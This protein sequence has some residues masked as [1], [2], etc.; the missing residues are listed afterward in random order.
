MAGTRLSKYG[1]AIAE[2]TGMGRIWIG[3]VLLATVT[4][5]PELFTGISS[6]AIIGNPDLTL[7]DL[8]GSNLINLFIIAI[9]DV[10]YTRGPILHYLGTGLVLAAIAS[11]FLIGIAAASI[12]VAQ[13]V[14]SMGLFNYIGI[15]SPVIF[16]LYLAI[17]YMLIR[18][19]RSQQSQTVTESPH[20]SNHEDISLKRVITFFVIISLAL[21]IYSPSFLFR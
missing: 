14:S 4:S 13:N 6:V 8:F 16:C 5:L 17:Q 15:Y 10:L 19:Q 18:F 20:P 3:V 21:S 11:S 7:G 9:L 12:Y 1:D 2:K